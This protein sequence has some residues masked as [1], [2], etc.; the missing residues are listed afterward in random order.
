MAVFL[1][2]QTCIGEPPVHRDFHSATAIG[3]NM[4]IFGGRS[5]LSGIGTLGPDYYSNKV[6]VSVVKRNSCTQGCGSGFRD[7]VDPD[8]YLKSGSRDKKTK[9]FQ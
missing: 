5:D 8:P 4:F 7:F 3:T 1:Y 2:L 9:K 6:S